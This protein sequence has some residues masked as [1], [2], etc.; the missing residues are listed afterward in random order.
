MKRPVFAGADHWTVRLHRLTQ[1]APQIACVGLDS[2]MMTE[3]ELRQQPEERV[4]DRTFLGD[5]EERP[6]SV[7]LDFPSPSPPEALP[8]ID[9]PMNDPA[10]GF[11]DD[12]LESQGTPIRC[13][14]PS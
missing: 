3:D 12:S 7:S 2:A 1:A 10:G 5:S 14:P 8:F 9:D 4:G 13:F 6:F 11:I